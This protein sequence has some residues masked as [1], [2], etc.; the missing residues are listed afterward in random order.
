MEPY[1]I[2][3][4]TAYTVSSVLLTSVLLLFVL[5]LGRGCKTPASPRTHDRNS[6]RYR[7]KRR[8]EFPPPFP[9]GWFH[10]CNVTDVEKG[11]VHTISALG[12]DLVA[13]KGK[14]S[15]TVAVLDAHCPHLGA[16]LG[17]GGEV[18]GDNLKCPFHGWEFST[19]GKV[20]KIPYASRTMKKIP[21]KCK[22]KAWEVRVLLDKVWL[23]HDAEGRPPLYEL[24]EYKDVEDKA[25]TLRVVRQASFDQHIA[26]MCENSA[27]PYHFQTLHGPLPIAGLEKVVGCRH[28]ITQKYPEGD[29]DVHICRFT[30]QMNDLELWGGAFSFRRW[31]PGAALILDSITT[32][33]AFEGPGEASEAEQAARRKMRRPAGLKSHCERSEASRE[34]KVA[35]TGGAEITL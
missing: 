13:F 19:E 16:H 35:K 27:D 29:E 3:V 4:G 10:V 34:A 2:V 6:A 28:V 33:V 25:M 20:K 30:E 12:L 14:D 11:K 7:R 32:R 15:G 17:E 5:L 21:D 26:E 24:K 9:N 22:T 31:I 8:A 1:I 18:E 23:W